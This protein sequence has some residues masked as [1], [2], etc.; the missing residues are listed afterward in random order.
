[1]KH[2]TDDLT[3]VD[4]KPGDHVWK[5]IGMTGSEHNECVLCRAK[6]GGLGQ[7]ADESAALPCTWTISRRRWGLHVSR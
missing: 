5:Q 4:Y 6:G 3:E 1:M 2:G 7:T